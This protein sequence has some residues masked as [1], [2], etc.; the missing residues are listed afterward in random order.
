MLAQRVRASMN[1]EL[2]VLG[3]LLAATAMAL[4][5]TRTW[6]FEQ[7]GKTVQADVVAIEG[8][9]VMLR[10]TDGKTNSIRIAY[11]TASDRAF[12]AAERAKQWKEVEVV[13]LKVGESEGHYDKCIVQ[14]KEVK[15]E[16]LIARLP[17]SVE[18]I[19]NARNQQAV[20][21]TNLS[22]QIQNQNLAVQQANA[23]LPAGTSGSRAYRQAVAAER[24]QVNLA[25][26]QLKEK[27]ASLAKLQ[28]SYDDTLK[29]TRSQTVVKMRNTG[30]ALK[31]LPV[32]ECYDPRRPD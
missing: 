7:S 13:Q 24:A 27:R 10:G 18:A 8:D 32:W 9:T 4:A 20:Q 17:S 14:G 11:L 29:K 21:I 30:V 16:I 15:G 2:R 19:L 25:S 3:L 1:T 6:T 26:K 12:L 22:V 31:G 5:E 28:K 23:A